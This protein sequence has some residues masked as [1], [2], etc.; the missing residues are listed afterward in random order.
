METCKDVVTEFNEQNELLGIQPVEVVTNQPA[1]KENATQK[2]SMKRK[3]YPVFGGKRKKAK[4]GKADS[5]SSDQVLLVDVDD[6]LDN[7]SATDRIPIEATNNDGEEGGDLVPNTL[8]ERSV[9]GD[10]Q[11]DSGETVGIVDLSCKKDLML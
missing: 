5:K 3:S 1:E 4:I 9:S 10:N 2:S 8:K 11:A 6:N 7:A